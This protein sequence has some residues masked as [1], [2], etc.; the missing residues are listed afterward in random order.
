MEE[1]STKDIAR[2]TDLAESTIRKY[3][4]LLEKNDYPFV[5]NTVGNRIFSEHDIKIFLEI[6][7]VP[8]DEKT[9][10]EIVAD[11]A[12]KYIVKAVTSKFEKSGDM[13]LNQ[14]FEPDIASI[15]IKKIDEL[16]DMNQKQ[17]DFN[18]ELVERLDQQQKYIDERLKERDLNLVE[19][20]RN[21]Q[22]EKRALSEIAV[23]QEEKKKG[24]FARL[25]G[26]KEE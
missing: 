4:L 22:E 26:K 14:V 17:L 1:Y 9:I 15:L 3:A 8:K 19:S 18:K 12:S 16:H 24:F 2:L 21:L 6:K 11:I 23:T 20:I 5:R 13:P 10:E 25:F 7:S